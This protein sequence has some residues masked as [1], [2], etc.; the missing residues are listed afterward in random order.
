[1]TRKRKGKKLRKMKR[2]RQTVDVVKCESKKGGGKGRSSA[3]LTE[4]T[5][6]HA[7]ARFQN[8]HTRK[9]SFNNKRVYFLYIIYGS[10]ALALF[11]S[12][13]LSDFAAL[14]SF[15]R[16]SDLKKEN[17]SSGFQSGPRKKNQEVKTGK[18]KFQM[19]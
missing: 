9:P 17:A 4:L 18:R 14:L 2:A 19:Q 1:M 13:Q 8:P 16:K 15:P 5:G 3:Q 10:G 7:L 11:A 6:P 12:Q